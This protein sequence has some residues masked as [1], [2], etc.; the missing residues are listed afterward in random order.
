MKQYRTDEQFQ[1]M[2]ENMIN[3]NWSDA[4]RNCA[5]YGFYAG[6][7][8]IKQEQAR[9]EGTNL[10]EDDLDFAK[11]IEIAQKYR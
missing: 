6:D 11:V 3:G 5:E 4:G 8:R 9:M 1:E 2:C 10:I 7:I